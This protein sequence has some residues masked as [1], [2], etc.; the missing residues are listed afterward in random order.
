MAWSESFGEFADSVHKAL[1]EEGVGGGM[2][3]R[4]HPLAD[5][6]DIAAVG[7]AVQQVQCQF[8]MGFI[9]GL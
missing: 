1:S 8:L 3:C 7:D 4:Q 9:F 2:Q 6:L 5:D